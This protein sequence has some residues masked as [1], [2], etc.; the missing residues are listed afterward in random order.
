[1]RITVKSDNYT[2][3][4]TN[5]E[6]YNL[7]KPKTE[8]E[9]NKV[10][11]FSFTIY[12]DHPHFDFIKKMK[13]I[14][15]VVEEGIAE[16]LFRGR[17]YDEKEGFYNE[18]QVTCEGELAF[19][20][21]SMQRPWSFTGTPEDLFKQFIAAHNE[22]VD[23]DRQF[24]VGKVT[25]TDPNDYIT[26]SDSECK[27]TWNAI[28]DKL[29]DTLGGY[30]W[31]RHEDGVNYIDY[32]ADFTTISNQP[33]EFGK[34]LLD[35]SKQ[36]KADGFATAIIPYGAKLTDEDGNETG[37]RLTIADVNDGVDYVYNEEAVAEHNYIFTTNTW[38]DVTDANNLK[39]K[40]QEYIDNM[41][42]FIASISVTAADLNG[43]MI[44]GKPVNVNSFRIGR[45][46]KVATK[47]HGLD[48]N[49]IVSKLTRELL[50]PEATKLTLGTTYKSLTEKQKETAAIRGEAGVPGKDG[51]DGNDG[52]N[53][54]DGR[55]ITSNT[56]TYQASTSGTVIPTST[57]S[58]TI[59]TVTEN[60]YLWTKIVLTYSD[61][62]TSTAYSVGKIG[63]NGSDGK[64][65]ENGADG[66][67]GKGVSSTTITYQASTSG[68][69][70]PTGTWSESIPTVAAN[71]YLWT[72]TV[73]AYT[74]STSSTA[75]SVGR[76]GAD[77]KDGSNGKDAAVQSATEPSDTSYMWLDISVEPPLLKWYN[78]TTSAWEATNDM[79]A[80]SDSIVQ[81]QENV[82]AD[83]S[84]TAEEILMTVSESYSTVGD[85]ERLVSETK[86]EF[87]QT[88]EDF[89][90]RFTTFQADLDD[91]AAGT[92][93]EFAEIKKYI[94]FVDGK[95]LLGEVGNQLELQISNDRISFLQDNAEVA[96]FNNRKL[97]VTDGEYTNSL[98]L[99]NFAYIPRTNG[100]LSFKKMN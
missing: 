94:R 100:N 38:D 63:A 67:D 20:N 18:K 10:G 3:M 41:A 40:A 26:R 4:D 53:G 45:Y 47:P 54:Q 5:L 59:P 21:D 15:T 70:V 8:Q 76:M 65:G 72:R 42:Q 34:N 36:I 88:A 6:S 27:N 78:T 92:D 39:R 46:V 50:K 58:A 13:S 89:E 14:I 44:D 98:T 48:Q 82:Y 56:I 7:V 91:I 64:D 75:Y 69:T 61:N 25:V 19:L 85:T 23:A 22:Q 77:G 90:M 33:I 84:K 87:E 11:K 28:N 97:Y 66:K 24:T 60:Q 95:I 81:L 62:T 51:K 79:T 73:F 80:I 32:L 30:L 1:M 74:D 86:T 99:G 83:I 35:L 17:V 52:A 37:E 12:P 31:T 71:Q 43:A 16:P 96:Y 55:G 57:W 93:A 68:T 9:T 49:F 2:L 29:I